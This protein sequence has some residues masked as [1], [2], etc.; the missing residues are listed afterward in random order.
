MTIIEP[1]KAKSS[2]NS[3]VLTLVLMFA[4]FV[5]LNIYFY[6]ETVNL[7]H[8]ISIASKNLQALQVANAESR[9]ELY[10][11]TDLSALDDL[12]KSR[13]LVKER[14][15]EYFENKLEALAVN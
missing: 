2:Y 10:K 12:A 3:T 11:L 5:C 1:H 6:N 7:K 8:S 14:K 13:G 9:T 4:A 15:P